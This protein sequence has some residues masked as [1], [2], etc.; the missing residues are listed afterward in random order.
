VSTH[1]SIVDT[2]DE[3]LRAPTA[4]LQTN[5]AGVEPL[6]FVPRLT[7]PTSAIALQRNGDSVVENSFSCNPSL[8]SCRLVEPWKSQAHQKELF[9]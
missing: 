4:F 6:P 7:R 8:V 1:T 2:S 9:T 5:P 3:Q